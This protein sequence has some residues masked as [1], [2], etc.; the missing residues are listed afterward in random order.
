LEL[1]NK[2]LP[3]STK[4]SIEKIL[5][6]S[7]NMLRTINDALDLNKI[8]DGKLKITIE[9]YDISSLISDVSKPLELRI[10]VSPDIPSVFFGDAQR[11]KQILNNFISNAV[12]C[13]PK[14]FV[15]LSVSHTVDNGVF[16]LKFAVKGSGEGISSGLGISKKLAELM[17][18]VI[19][20]AGNDIS[21]V[22]PQVVKDHTP[23]GEE[24][25]QKLEFRGASVLAVDDVAMNLEIVNRFLKQYN[26]TIETV[27]SGQK[28]IDIIKAGNK[29]DVIFMDHLM[30]GMDGIEAVKIIRGMGGYYAKN[31][32][33]IAFTANAMEGNSKIFLENGFDDFI[34]KPLDA[35][36]LDVCLNKWIRKKVVERSEINSRTIRY[37]I[38]MNDGIAQF[39]SE[40]M[41]NKILASFKKHTPKLLL[42]LQEKSGKDY[43][44]AVHA[45]KGCV[46]TIFA[47]ELGERAFELETA[48]KEGNW[49][50]VKNKNEGF[51][52]DIQKIV[53][54]ISVD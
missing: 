25:A 53:E 3:Y 28:A 20:V 11:I 12:K 8:E 9:K 19:E 29:F 5:N 51:I 43:I 21:L 48:A 36:K 39:G 50:L 14:G 18:G 4:N 45:L 17:N 27:S 49:E 32:P 23:I 33:I 31:V 10:S 6:L 2:K 44:I 35:A 37:H 16:Y 41:F 30:P 42:D 38:D 47:N 24:M 40:E 52:K 26:L 7:N 54:A 34:S 13:T 1:E 15:E 46:K 22:I